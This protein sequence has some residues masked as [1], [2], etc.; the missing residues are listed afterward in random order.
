[1]EE[2]RVV[3]LEVFFI[4]ELGVLLVMGGKWE[5]EGWYELVD[6]GDDRSDYYFCVGCVG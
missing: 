4:M 1:M 3:W 2:D 5:V 6:D